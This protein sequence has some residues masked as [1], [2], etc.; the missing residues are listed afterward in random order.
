VKRERAQR[1]N[2]PEAPQSRDRGPHCQSPG[3]VVFLSTVSERHF[4]LDGCHHISHYSVG[5]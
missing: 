4:R 3:I 2:A 1:V 5:Y